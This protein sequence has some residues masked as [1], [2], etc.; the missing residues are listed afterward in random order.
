MFKKM[1]L[2]SYRQLDPAIKEQLEKTKQAI[3]LNQYATYQGPHVEE[4]F[5]PILPNKRIKKTDRLQY[6]I[7]KA[8]REVIAVKYDFKH[9]EFV[10]LTPIK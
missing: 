3:Q 6:V 9:K 2:F 5:E 7:E 10:V 1:R 4:L 8:T